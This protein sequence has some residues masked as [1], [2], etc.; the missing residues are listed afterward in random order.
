MHTFFLKWIKCFKKK[1]KI[2]FYVVRG[3]QGD[4]TEEELSYKGVDIA[5]LELEKY[6]PLDFARWIFFTKIIYDFPII[7]QLKT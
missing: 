4:A 2:Y 6:V 5:V 7:K 1:K 3:L